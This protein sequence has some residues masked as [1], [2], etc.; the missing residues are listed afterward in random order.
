MNI[1]NLKDIFLLIDDY[2]TYLKEHNISIDSN[3]FPVFTP[4]MFLTQ[5]PDL[6]IPFSQRKNKRVTNKSRTV[7]CFYDKDNHLYPRFYKLLAEIS[8]YKSYMGVI[9]IDVTF[10]D[11]MDEEWQKAT[12]LLNQ[13][14]LAVLAVNDIKIVL[15]TRSASLDANSLWRNVPQGVMAASG[16]LGCDPLYSE[17][18]FS[19]LK[20]ILLLLPKK[21]IIYGKHDL[22]AEKQLD[23]MGIDYRVYKD[24]HRLCKEVRHG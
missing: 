11:D 24:F 22:I 16:F 10:T 20:K 7:I 13:L 5:W 2:Y 1:Q 8:E 15:N 17:D 14:F 21:L 4:D 18:D 19:F 3:G 6:V 9:G 12:A 23:S